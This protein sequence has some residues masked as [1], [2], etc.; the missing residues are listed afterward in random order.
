[1]HFRGSRT[2]ARLRPGTR[3][4]RY[5]G[6]LIAVTFVLSLVATGL[7]L[8]ASN[9]KPTMDARTT[10]LEQAV[11]RAGFAKSV[12]TTLASNM[13]GFDWNGKSRGTLE[14][15]TLR[16]GKWSDWTEIDGDPS[17]GPDAGSRE[18]RN[19]ITSA[20][21]AWVGDGVRALQV[22]AKV[23]A[24]PGLR[25]HAIPSARTSGPLPA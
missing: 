11:A 24:M 18:H 12:H 17:E 19:N 6:R 15:R 5:L 2:S 7:S 20:G 8:P 3:S 14:F 22:R 4:R 9:A 16:A 25:P 13:V 10:T 21:P 23:R 1:M